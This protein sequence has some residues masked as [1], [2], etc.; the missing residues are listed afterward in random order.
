MTLDEFKKTILK[1]IDG[2][3]AQWEDGRSKDPEAWPVSMG[4]G[5][6]LDQ[7]LIWQ[8]RGDA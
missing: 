5:D 1:D 8:S 2:F 4:E 7:F 6:W 3:A